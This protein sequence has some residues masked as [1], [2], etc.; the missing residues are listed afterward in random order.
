M[1]ASRTDQIVGLIHD[2]NA[3]LTALRGQS[4]ALDQISEHISMLAQQIHGFI[5]ENRATLKPALEKLNGVL[6]TI[7]NRKKEVQE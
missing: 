2:T 5:G 7:D 1:L 6:A 3:V 4:A